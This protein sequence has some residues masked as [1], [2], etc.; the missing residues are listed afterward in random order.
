MPVSSGIPSQI[1][2][3]GEE[4]FLAAYDPSGYERPSVTVDVVLLS[5][6]Q[7]QLATVV[8]RRAEHPERGR[9]AL[10][11][12][13]VGFEE[14]LEAAASR[15]LATKAGLER[16]FLEQLYTF[17]Q[18]HRDPRTRVITVAYYALVSRDRLAA[19]RGLAQEALIVVPWEGEAGGPVVLVDG[20]GV[21][22]P[23]AFDHD[24]IVGMAVQRLRG[25]V[26][27]AP[28]GFELLPD[29]FTLRQLQEVHE[30]ILGR[31]LNKDSFRRRML[32]SGRLRGTGQRQEEVGHRPAELFGF[33]RGAS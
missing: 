24:R 15:V 22:M 3:E 8:V 28:L 1:P 27:Y 25:K 13:F 2:D 10:P 31:P 30:A 12:G 18:P 5:V 26:N 14:T 32:A 9:W 16:V 19:A 4:A 20:A 7:G 33:V 6:A 29:T 21:P 23:L 17:G 11:G